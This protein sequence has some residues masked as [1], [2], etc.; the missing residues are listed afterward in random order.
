S[1]DPHIAYY[2]RALSVFARSFPRGDERA[3]KGRSHGSHPLHALPRQIHNRGKHTINQELLISGVHL[4]MRVIFGK[5]WRCFSASHTPILMDDC[6][7]ILTSATQ[8]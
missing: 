2:E 6:P 8:T 3:G 7:P 1:P 4:H 5:S